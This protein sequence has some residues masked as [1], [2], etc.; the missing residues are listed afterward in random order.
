[1]AF[2]SIY[3]R[4][5]QTK[6]HRHGF[7]MAANV[8]AG[9]ANYITLLQYTNQ[10]QTPITG[11]DD[12]YAQFYVA[13]GSIVKK[14]W[15]DMTIEPASNTKVYDLYIGWIQLSMD[16]I[17]SI[18]DTQL[19]VTQDSTTDRIDGAEENFNLA[20]FRLNPKNKH[21]IRGMKKL[22]L[23][24]GKPAQV[25]KWLKVPPKCRRGQKGMYWALYVA[26]ATANTSGTTDGTVNIRVSRVFNEFPLVD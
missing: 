20:T 11:T 10:T 4:K 7:D 23:Y 21:F 6:V 3:T 15:L 13:D 26:N 9:K 17:L 24:A 8:P 16:E 25:S 22:T 14:V 5:A 18:P 1:M 19:N 12:Q 2:G